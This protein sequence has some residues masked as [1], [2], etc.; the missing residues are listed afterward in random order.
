MPRTYQSTGKPNIYRKAN[1]LYFR[2]VVPKDI[3]ELFGQRE[4]YK[5][6]Q[7]SDLRL[8]EEKAAVLRTS[9]RREFVYPTKIEQ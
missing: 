6:L 5:S 7:T 3:V 9:L 8:A 1:T 4:V 2:M